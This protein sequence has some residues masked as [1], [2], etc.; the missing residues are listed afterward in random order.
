M[1]ESEARGGGSPEG[2]GPGAERRGPVGPDELARRQLVHELFLALRR[3]FVLGGCRD[4][5]TFY[6]MAKL[7]LEEGASHLAAE[8][9]ADVR[10]WIESGSILDLGFGCEDACAVIPLYAGLSA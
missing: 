10:S 6:L 4:C 1:S 5:E 9:Q 2:A 8:E 3:G 7:C